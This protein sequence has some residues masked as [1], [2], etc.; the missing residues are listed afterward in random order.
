[1]SPGGEPAKASGALKDSARA[2]DAVNMRSERSG[3]GAWGLAGAVAAAS[4]LGLGACA[5]DGM[6]E[7]P[8][9]TSV[10]TE[11]T[12]AG[13]PP[14]APVSP[15]IAYAHQA[16]RICYASY[17]LMNA[18]Q[19]RSEQLKRRRGWTN[20][21]TEGAIRYGF[22]HGMLNQYRMLRELGP[23]PR[24]AGVM[25]RWTRTALERARLQRAIGDAW[26]NGEAERASEL[27]LEVALAK[28]KADVLAERLPFRT[29]GTP[30][31]H[32]MFTPT[33]REQIADPPQDYSARI[34]STRKTRLLVKRETKVYIRH[35]VVGK[36]TDVVRG[37][38]TLF[39]TTH[40]KRR[41]ARQA[42]GLGM[43]L[44]QSAREPN[45]G[46][47]ALERPRP[48]ADEGSNQAPQT[49]VALTPVG[50]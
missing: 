27:I 38:D 42:I 31:D 14:P 35:Q 37:E 9:S 46:W 21:A 19:E 25:K 30:E 47:F 4:A 45:L 22:A 23:A 13:T 3:W 24:M 34:A 43:Q 20:R 12:Q 18:N 8:A 32:S 10:A 36:V 16:D 5:D 15:L 44:I 17:Q 28:E 40:L 39:I 41:Y 49:L 48:P 26:L 33:R 6:E 29:C 11:S 50:G 2:A 7:L 1:M